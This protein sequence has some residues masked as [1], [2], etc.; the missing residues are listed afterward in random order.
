MRLFFF[1]VSGNTESG[2][3]RDEYRVQVVRSVARCTEK[4]V[5]I[6]IFEMMRIF[7]RKSVKGTEIQREYRIKK[8]KKYLLMA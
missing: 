8:K 5:L 3:K 4:S 1:S 7:I 6:R 2:R